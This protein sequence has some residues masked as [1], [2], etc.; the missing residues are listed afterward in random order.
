MSNHLFAFEFEDGRRTTTGEPNKNT[1]NLSIAGQAHMFWDDVERDHWV[2]GNTLNYDKRTDQRIR[3]SKQDL[4][5]LHKGMSI[6]E[7]EDYI[8]CLEF[9]HSQEDV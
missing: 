9:T 2:V 8:D 5:S 1:G 7:Y 3:T 4:R 6:R